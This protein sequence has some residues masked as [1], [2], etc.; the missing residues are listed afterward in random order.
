MP[1][2]LPLESVGDVMRLG[3]LSVGVE[4]DRVPVLVLMEVSAVDIGVPVP[5]W[6]CK[7]VPV[8]A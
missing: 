5:L 2:D 8:W 3:L 1:P 7:W 4:G 6:V